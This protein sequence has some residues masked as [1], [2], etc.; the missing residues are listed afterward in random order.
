M[1]LVPVLLNA[2]PKTKFKSVR[3]E[4]MLILDDKRFREVLVEMLMLSSRAFEAYVST[5]Q[6][7][8]AELKI[9]CG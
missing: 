3:V 1:L 6:S 8:Y 4:V 9:G 2:C 7:N 5:I